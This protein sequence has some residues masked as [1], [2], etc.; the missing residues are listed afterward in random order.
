LLE[1]LIADQR[2]AL[3][4]KKRKTDK[5]RLLKKIEEMPPTRDLKKALENPPS[6]FAVIAEIKWAS[7]SKGYLKPEYSAKKPAVSLARS[8]EQ[9]GAAALSVIT[10]EDNFKGELSDLEKIKKAVKIPV[11]RKDFILEEYQLYEARAFGADAVLLMGS[12]LKEKE[13]EK[14]LNLA[15]KLNLEALVEIKDLPE[16]EKVLKAGPGVVG[17][18]NRN[19]ETMK[20]DFKTLKKLVPLIPA[21]ITVVSESGIVSFRQMKKIKETVGINKFLIGSILAQSSHPGKKLKEL[22]NP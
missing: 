19:L 13:L 1:K 9:A 7:P 6:E 3:D 2:K 22:L 15:H 11:M 10:E 20:I 21:G 18:N 14:L 4:R 17:V 5:K 16:L 12:I 8:Y